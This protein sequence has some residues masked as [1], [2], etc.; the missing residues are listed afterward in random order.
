MQSGG[1]APALPNLRCRGFDSSGTRQEYGPGCRLANGRL[2]VPTVNVLIASGG[3]RNYLVNWFREALAHNRVSGKVVVSDSNP[4]A[5]A[6][7]DADIPV[8]VPAFTDH[9]YEG[10]LLSVMT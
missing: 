8:V 3:R 4:H 6:L 9:D 1:R 10:T 7:A 2:A 5:P